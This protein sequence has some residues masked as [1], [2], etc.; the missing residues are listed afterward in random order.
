MRN[1]LTFIK[2]GVGIDA[3]RPYAVTSD[4]HSQDVSVD[5]VIRKAFTGFTFKAMLRN[6]GKK[7]VKIRSVRWIRDPSPLWP[8]PTLV[9]ANRLEP[10]Y[11][12]SEGYRG[13]IFPLGTMVGE[14]LFHPLTN[15][16]VTVGLHED[17]VV[18]GVFIGSA[19]ESLGILLMAAEH[20]KTSAKFR[21]RGGNG[22][23]RWNLEIEQYPQGQDGFVLLPGQTAGMDTLFVDI[24]KTNDPQLSTGS[25][26]KLLRKTGHFKRMDTNPLH[27]QRIWQTWNYGTYFAIDEGFVQKQ[28]PLIKKFFPSVKFIQIDSGYERIYPTGQLAQ[29]DLLYK[30][31]PPHNTKKFPHGMKW[32]ADRIREQGLRPSIW[33]ALWVSES[34]K[35]VKE[36]PEWILFDDAGR[37]MKVM[38][39]CGVFND[40]PRN[41]VI[42]DPTVPAYRAYIE[43]LAKTVFQ[44]WGYEG[45]KLDFSSFPFNIRTARYRHPEFTAAE[46]RDWCVHTFRKYLPE[47][48]FFGWCSAVG[49]GTPFYGPADY[50]RYAEDI[51][52]GNWDLA[53]RIAF[54]TTNTNMLLSERTAI[55]HIDSIGW[56]K[57][58]SETQW[59][60]YLSLCAVTGN[61]FEVSGDL[62]KLDDEK[63]RILNTALELSDTRATFRILDIPRGVLGLPPSLWVSMMKGR[64]RAALLVNWSDSSSKIDT[65][66]LDREFPDWNKLTP[67]WD[68]GGKMGKGFV[69]LPPFASLFLTIRRTA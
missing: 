58:F 5:L 60:T 44:D 55:P 20:K 11:Y 31:V 53:K 2:N 47:D 63:L 56:A 27:D 15:Q 16:D 1:V 25:Y 21:F 30:N 14:Q 50:F 61:E 13:E 43:K 54:W 42:L 38:S 18:P 29:G 39:K 24:V 6:T 8:P 17:W 33:L 51:G 12:S 37:Q 65:K 23:D 52:D 22:V 41:L 68:L 35:L 9:F 57:D 64:L 67:V 34:S 36:H 46:C 4:G 28:I 48:G 49:A 3:L 45:V 59:L 32:L 19:K 69:K 7:S 10:F 26:Y 40:I 66:P 62:T